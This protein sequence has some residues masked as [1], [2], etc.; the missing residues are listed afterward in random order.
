MFKVKVCDIKCHVYKIGKETH[1]DIYICIYMYTIKKW[2]VFWV[3]TK[4][5]MEGIHYTVN[6]HDM[7][8]Y[9]KYTH[10]LHRMTE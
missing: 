9:D 3:D 4:M 10:V 7:L 8:M 5:T 2:V 1:G 6:D